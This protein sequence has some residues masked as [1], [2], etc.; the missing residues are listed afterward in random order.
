MS[1][2][3]IIY[4]DLYIFE[5]EW[6]FQ[7][8]DMEKSGSTAMH[9]YWIV[10]VKPD[11]RRLRYGFNCTSKIGETIHYTERGFFE[12][13]PKDKDYY[14]CFP[15]LHKGD[16]FQAPAWVKDTVWYQIFPERFDNGDSSNDPKGSLPWGKAEPSSTNFFGGDFQGVIDQLDYLVDLGISGIYFTPIFKAQ[17][18][19]KYDTMNYM[20]IDPQFGDK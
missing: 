19:H 7:V 12:F 10:A 14:F 20:E 15:Y 4:D 11:F 18:N 8:I 13:I 17:S 16:V 3:S 5:K 6:Q 1:A 9:D 2:L